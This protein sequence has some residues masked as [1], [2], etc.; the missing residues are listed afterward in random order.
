MPARLIVI[1]I[2]PERVKA[3]G[4]LWADF[5]VHQP[6]VEGIGPAYRELTA[7]AISEGWNE[8]LIILQD[9]VALKDGESWAEHLGDVTSYSAAK[10]YRERRLRP[11]RHCCPRAFSATGPGWEKLHAAWQSEGKLC[12]LWAPDHIYDLVIH[13][14]Q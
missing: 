4:H 10:P 5:E 2:Y 12:E 14:R 9:D 1:S 13:M 7:R 6:T 8:E 3:H 11:R